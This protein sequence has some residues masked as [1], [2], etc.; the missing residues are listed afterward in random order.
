MELRH[1]RY[2]VAVAEEL[3]FGRAALKLNIAQP[4]L[5]QQIRDLEQEL[6]ARLFHRTS[7]RVEMTAHGR[8][9]LAEAR[10]ILSHARRASEM[11]KASQRGEFGSISIG[12]V[13]SAIYS[14]MTPTL[15]GFHS[16]FPEVE[17]HCREMATPEQINALHKRDI[18][19]GFLRTPITDDSIQTHLLQREFLVLVLPEDH[20][21]A[22]QSKVRLQDFASEPFILFPRRQ[23]PGA[24]D[25]I[26]TTCQNAGFSP[27]LAQ[28]GN[29]MQSMLGLVAAGLGVSLVPASLQ[30]L[31]RPGIVYKPLSTPTSEIEISL[32][33]RK[34]ESDPVERSF[35]EAALRIAKRAKR[36]R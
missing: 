34:G 2:F 30:N 7:R 8:L 10:D 24:Y 29:E 13:T 5:S 19:I 18:S 14:V 3:H 22:R 9:F 27:I 32:A 6:G 11:V 26:I 17:I 12:F 31:R 33:M 21:A 23:G 1:L 36:Q 15:R 35:I 20:P 25:Q 28:E 4:P 16:Q